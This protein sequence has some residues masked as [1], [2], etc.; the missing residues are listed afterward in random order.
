M[1]PPRNA[2]VQML[3]ALREDPEGKVDGIWLLS[4]KAVYH[5]MPLLS[6]GHPL[7]VD[8]NVMMTEVL[9]W[10]E[11]LDAIVPPP[12][13]PAINPIVFYGD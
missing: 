1:S 10:E 4:F 3:T 13:P 6:T 2:P 7:S 12:P 8:Y 11:D 5:R 9:V